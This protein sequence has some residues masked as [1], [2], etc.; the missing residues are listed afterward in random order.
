MRNHYVPQKYLRGFCKQGSDRMLWQYDKVTDQFSPVSIKSAANEHDF[1]PD[2]VE[3]KLASHIESPANK[4]IDKLRG[5]QAINDQERAHLAIYIA[6]MLKRVPRHRQRIAAAAPLSL[7]ETL[8]EVK[9]IIIRAAEAGKL[10]ADAEAKRL[11]EV[12]SYGDR[13]KHHTPE[14]VLEKVLR[15]W[16]SQEMAQLIYLM[17]WRFITTKEPPF[18]ITSDNP[19]FFFECYG[20]KGDD[21]ELTF[22]IASDLALHGCWQPLKLG[23]KMVQVAK[24]LVKE[25]NRRIANS[26]TRFIYNCQKQEWVRSLAQ[27]QEPH[28]NRIVW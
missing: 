22:P 25:F 9:D 2:D 26:A 16:P 28:L 20:L 12:E 1:Y 14:T 5:G 17:E 27:R 4:V 19:A 7:T 6:T 11:A 3:A 13:F 8:N 21:A 18:F 24:Q 23:E 10:S 15:P